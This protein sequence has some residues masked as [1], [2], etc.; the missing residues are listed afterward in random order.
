MV[1]K[2]SLYTLDD[3][4]RGIR[5]LL[6]CVTSYVAVPI[7][8]GSQNYLTINYGNHVALGVASKFSLEY[9]QNYL[10]AES[11]VET[12]G[13]IYTVLDDRSQQVLNYHWHPGGRSRI[14]T[15]HLHLKQGARVSLAEV[16]DA[17]LPTGQVTLSAFLEFLIHDFN[18]VPLRDDWQSVMNSY[19]DL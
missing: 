14:V 15:P 3:Y 18:V 4:I 16:R 10:V 11:G 5:L 19:T 9:Q 2:S 7:K 13:Y 1:G 12:I 17:H 8:R 6:S